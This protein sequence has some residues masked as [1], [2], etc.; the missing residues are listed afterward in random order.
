M[1]EPCRSLEE[2]ERLMKMQSKKGRLKERA[3]SDTGKHSVLELVKL[4]ESLGVPDPEP[5]FYFH[6]TRNWRFDMAWPA[7]AIGFEREGGTWG[8]SRHNTGKG[9]RDDVDKYNEASLLGWKVLRATVDMM[10]DGSAA[11]LILRA[12]G[13]S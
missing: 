2:V 12:F 1:I 13:L 7:Y 6:E 3:F 8:K 10:K 5:E 9:Y 4:L 11:S